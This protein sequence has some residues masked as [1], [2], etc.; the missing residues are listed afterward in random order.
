LLQSR[1]CVGWHW[2]K[3][4][5][6][7]PDD[8]HAE[9]SNVDSNKGIVDRF[10]KPYGALLSRMRDLNLQMYGVAD[11][12]DASAGTHKANVDASSSPTIRKP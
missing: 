2:F 5:D 11:V 6:N 12:F 7:D 3:Y 8:P 1:A 9:A 4:Q 10:Y